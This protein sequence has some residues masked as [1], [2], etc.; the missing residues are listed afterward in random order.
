ML[1]PS[2]EVEVKVTY[3]DQND[4]NTFSKLT[5]TQELVLNEIEALKQER[6]YLE[7][8]SEEMELMDE[9]ELVPY[10]I[11]D[12]FIEMKLEEVQEKISLELEKLKLNLEG[13]QNQAD[14]LVSDMKALKTKLY[15]KFGSSIHLEKD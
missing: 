8:L 11:G 10:Q 13:K 12:S 6:E 15:A 1:E 9:E 2:Q 3:Q 4:I 14:K 5:Q 7:E